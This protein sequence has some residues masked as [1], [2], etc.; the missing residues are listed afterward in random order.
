[1]AR[2]PR[3]GEPNAVPALSPSSGRGRSA[4]EKTVVHNN[5]QMENRKDV[6]STVISVMV[7][8]SF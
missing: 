4:M 5:P 8:V 7:V 1:M 3:R 6:D 2:P